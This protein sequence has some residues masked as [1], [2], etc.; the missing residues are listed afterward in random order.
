MGRSPYH[1]STF[2]RYNPYQINHKDLKDEELLVSL[3]QVLGEEAG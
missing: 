1:F 3:G 2:N